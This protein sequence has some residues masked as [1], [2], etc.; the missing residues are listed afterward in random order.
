MALASGLSF[1]SQLAA[2][3]GLIILSRNAA[4]AP[5]ARIPFGVVANSLPRSFVV[6]HETGIDGVK[7]V[8]E[9]V[10]HPAQP[11][12]HMRESLQRTAPR[13]FLDITRNR[14]NA[15]NALAFGFSTMAS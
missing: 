7:R 15:R 9:P 14:L 3:R 11:L 4:K 13:Q 2:S 6:G 10:H 12:S 1:G 8:H 5:I